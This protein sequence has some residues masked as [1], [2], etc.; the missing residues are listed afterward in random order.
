MGGSPKRERE[1][2]RIYKPVMVRE[3]ENACGCTGL[4]KEGED[5]GWTLMMDVNRSGGA[6]TTSFKA[7]VGLGR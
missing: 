4:R 2:R 5:R 7:R 6:V 1:K 3:Q